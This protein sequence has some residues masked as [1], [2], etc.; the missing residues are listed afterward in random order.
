MKS[1]NPVIKG[2]IFDRA[3]V[4][5][6]DN[7]M[8]TTGSINKT[9]FLLLLLIFSSSISWNMVGSPMGGM[10][11]IGSGLLG[12]V[13]ALVLTFKMNLAPVLAP[14]YAI[15]EGLLIGWISATYDRTM[16]G[17]VSNAAILTFATLG[18]MLLLYRFKILQATENFKRVIMLA[19]M[20]IMVVYLVDFVMMLFGLPI[21]F[22][23]TGSPVGIVFS[24]IV[25]GVAALNLILDFSFITQG[26]MRRAPKYMEWYAGF[27]LM[28]TLVWLY[29]EILR[30]LSKINRR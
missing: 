11:A 1:S 13:L 18:L 15:L 28:V 9:G 14:V 16:P 5:E 24:L 10:V 29:L 27:T 30:L 21:A 2:N 8:T 19:T 20:S 3:G 4:V 7:A 22:I 12:F 6:A 23:H 26:E 17:I 25:A